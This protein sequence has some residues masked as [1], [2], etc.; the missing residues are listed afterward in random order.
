MSGGFGDAF[1]AAPRVDDRSTRAGDAVAG[2]IPRQADRRNDLVH[3]DVSAFEQAVSAASAAL[4]GS[5]QEAHASATVEAHGS[6]RFSDW[7]REWGL[8]AEL[9]LAVT[10]GVSASFAAASQPVVAL[11]VLLTWLF[12][13][14][15][16]GR[17]V[18]TPLGSQLKTAVDSAV[19]PLAFLAGAV[20][21]AGVPATAVP[22]AVAA[23]TAGAVTSVLCR[24]LRWRLQSPV[25]VVV[26][27]DRAAVATATARWA[28]TPRV[29][30][31]GG[32]VLEAD[33]DTASVPRDILGVPVLA[34]VDQAR[35]QVLAWGADLVVV[36][37]CEAITPQVFRRITWALEGT[38][39]SLGVSG[40]LDAVAPHRISAGTLERSSIVDVRPPRPSTV[41][42]G[43]KGAAD[44]VAAAILIVLA[45]PLMALVA[46]AVRV[47]SPGPVIFS[48]SRVGLGGVTFRVHKFRTMVQDA[49]SLKAALGD[50]NEFDSV[51]FKM[52]RDPRITRIGRFLRKSSLD[53][54]PQLF[55]VLKGEMSLVGPR[56][57]LAE[58]TARMDEDTLR[59]LAVK[60][61]ITGLWQVSGRSDLS[62]EDSVLLDLRYVDNWS[63]AMDLMILWKTLRAVAAV[64]GAY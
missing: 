51:L 15:H 61:G 18:T 5:S 44:R 20:G 49:D 10:A 21:F 63:P 8:H 13:N 28:R 3:E 50:S 38:N 23:V 39:A 35:S 54:L 47:D 46:V 6:T 12:G 11:L 37:P 33:L 48:Q 7:L 2:F 57:F 14:Y 31:V 30:V 29:R 59:R 58:E 34:G 53:E 45:A 27:G 55:N 22:Q 36:A 43:I 26:V 25:R 19:L 40:V 1:V 42:R 9:V 41:V 56:P 4:V 17:A 24:T 60:P 32:L 64:R 16:R 52:R 62:W